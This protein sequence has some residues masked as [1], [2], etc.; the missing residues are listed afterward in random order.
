MPLTCQSGR[1]RCFGFKLT[2]GLTLLFVS[3]A[4]G[5]T[6]RTDVIY[7]RFEP[8]LYSRRN[9]VPVLLEVR[10]GDGIDSVV[11]SSYYGGTPS[12]IPLNDQGTGGDKVAGD[13][14][15]SVTLQPENFSPDLPYKFIFD[16]VGGELDLY[17]G[18]THVITVGAGILITDSK[19]VN[20]VRLNSAT[21]Y[22]RNGVNLR[23]TD[24]EF[25]GE[26][27]FNQFISKRFYALFPD[28]F[29]MLNIVYEGGTFQNRTHDALQNQVKGIGVGIGSNT[30][31]YGSAGK[32]LG[33]NRFPIDSLLDLDRGRGSGYAFLHEMGHQWLVAVAGGD[34]H[35]PLSDLA[36]SG[37]MGYSGFGG[38]GQGIAG[39]LAPEG[40][41]YRV[42][43]WWGLTRPAYNDLELYLMGMVPASA[44]LPHFVFR[45]QN[46]ASETGHGGFLQGPVDPV[47]IEDIIRANGPR[48]PDSTTSQKTF[49][50]ATIFV[51]LDRSATPE[52][53][54]YY[55]HAATLMDGL[56]NNATL[57]AGHIDSMVKDIVPYPPAARPEI[58][59][60]G[61]ASGGPLISP[62]GW[63][64][65][66]GIG[67]APASVGRG[68]VWS[69]APE[70]AQGKMPTSLG[71]V[72]VRINGKPAYVYFVSPDQVN[73][74]AGLEAGFGPVKVEVTNGSQTSEPWIAERAVVSPS[75]FYFGTTNYIAA[76]HAN[77][78]LVGP[79]Y[80]S[81][82]GYSF[83][84]AKVG[85]TIILYGAGYGQTVGALTEGSSTQSGNLPFV[86]PVAF[87][88]MAFGGTTVKITFGGLVAPGL[89]QFN[90]VVPPLP[91]GDTVLLHQNNYG[92]IPIQP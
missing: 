10:V 28:D 45:N 69:S 88:G 73:V 16:N 37:M 80:L 18:A 2:L 22:S 48:V 64:E 26:G 24:A 25:F 86:P 55:D 30:S 1:S 49:R 92:L 32:L 12:K 44:V 4:L 79:A 6:L 60:V 77:G 57:G 27:Q 42:T 65:I 85:E 90:V 66:K 14:I 54:A 52:E 39:T 84:P 76:T 7:T 13:R 41:G 50:I 38:Q 17:R 74:L 53:M 82:P 67:L 36:A 51:T 71:G 35:W 87:G 89:Y 34:G 58:Q 72:T 43:E 62:N 11:F 59:W 63:I 9:P 40:T 5:Q 75:L 91:A 3:V 61:T 8:S 81:V 31:A 83:T 21:Q 46:Q 33:I 19:P 23:L 56:F 47:T 68:L 15:F 70:F 20:V 29:D 78:T